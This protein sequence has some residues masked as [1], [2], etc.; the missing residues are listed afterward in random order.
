VLSRTADL[1]SRGARR[2]LQ[3][4]LGLVWLLDGALQLQPYMFGP[5]FVTHVL[6]PASQGN[7]AVLA[8]PAMWAGRLIGHDV[9]AWNTVFAV[10]QLAIGAGLLWRP[11]VRAALVA[12][13]GWALS[14]W[15]LGEGL[16]GL[17]T[18]SAS[19]V[20]GAPGAVVLYAL[21]ALLVWPAGAGDRVRAGLTG[22]T[23]IR[24]RLAKLAWI[25]LWGGFAGL[26]LQP[27]VRA[28]RSLHDAIAAGAAGEPGWLGRLDRAAAAGIGS[29][30]A[31]VCGLLAA[32]FILI[33]AGVLW[34][35]TT[36]P[37]LILAAAT[38]VAIWVVGENLGQLFT[39]MATD[40]NT[41][42]L[43]VLLAA[44]YWPWRRRG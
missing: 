18:G 20:T 19:P 21:T 9:A 27:A 33:A 7:P 44:A 37:A 22:G 13:I 36:R 6:A 29:H 40:P 15:W 1:D 24:E 10:I 17:F 5:G 25:L 32:L 16:G 42:P 41:G 14:V 2:S 11:T 23:P 30:G 3:I 31:L 28:P 39:G 8:A 43:L 26:I 35:A 38:G 12:S 34:P 4:A